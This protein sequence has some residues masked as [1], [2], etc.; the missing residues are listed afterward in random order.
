MIPINIFLACLI[1]LSLA[2]SNP[3][4]VDSNSLPEIPKYVPPAPDREITNWFAIGDSF[5]AGISA[6]VPGDLINEAC[7]RFTGSYPNQMNQDPRLP[8]S[9]TRRIF[10][11]A[12]CSD[13]KT[14]I[15]KQIDVLLPNTDANFPRLEKPQIGTVSLYW[16]DIG[17][18]NVR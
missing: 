3:S 2:S 4:D 1:R 8:G 5:S 15:R 9:A 17:L 12:S 7:N 14:D 11:F 13:P 6:D 16:D 18:A 10:A